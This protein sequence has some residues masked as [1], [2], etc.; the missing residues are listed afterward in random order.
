MLSGFQA[1]KNRTIDG[2]HTRKWQPIAMRYFSEDFL[3]NL[4]SGD[5]LPRSKSSQHATEVFLFPRVTYLG[6]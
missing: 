4:I 1:E 3:A 5:K 2:E 6:V